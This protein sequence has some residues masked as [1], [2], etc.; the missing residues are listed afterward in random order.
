MSTSSILSIDHA[1]AR[2]EINW[3]ALVRLVEAWKGGD[4]AALTG[5][6]AMV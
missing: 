2:E 1:T 4:I 3:Q 6:W 5:L